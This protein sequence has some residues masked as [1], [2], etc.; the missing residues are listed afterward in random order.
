MGSN[1]RFAIK[2]RLIHLTNSSV[3]LDFDASTIGETV[4]GPLEDGEIDKDSAGHFTQEKFTEL[5]DLQE[6]G[7][8]G[9]VRLANLQNAVEK[10]ASVLVPKSAGVKK[11]KDFGFNLTK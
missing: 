7:E 6:D 8:L 9:P 11:S 1:N 3:K 4:S 2:P 5:S 10:L